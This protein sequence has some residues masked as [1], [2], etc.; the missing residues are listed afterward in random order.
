MKRTVL[1]TGAS[2]GIGSAICKKLLEGGHRVIGIGR[3]F[4]GLDFLGADYEHAFSPLQIDM[5]EL[6]SL[7]DQLAS[8]K[9]EFPD[10]NSIICCAGQGRFGSLEEFS[11]QQINDLMSINFVANAFVVRAFI[12]ALKQNN[13]GDKSNGRVIT[14]HARQ[15][16]R[17]IGKSPRQLGLVIDDDNDGDT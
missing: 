12:P 5:A 14:P 7:S 4:S 13:R 15:A 11:Y 8:I 9:K 17:I 2:G 6:D 10:I 1:V 16:K 3:D